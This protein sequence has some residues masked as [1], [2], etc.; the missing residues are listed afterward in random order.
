MAD[1]GLAAL[2]IW[3]LHFNYTVKMLKFALLTMDRH[4]MSEKQDLQYFAKS[5]SP[6]SSYEK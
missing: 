6:S 2:G 1:V 3:G 4:L 5:F